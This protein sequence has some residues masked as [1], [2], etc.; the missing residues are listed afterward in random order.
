MGDWPLSGGAQ[1]LTT[2]AADAAASRGTT[3]TAPGANNTKGAYTELVASSAHDADALLVVLQIGLNA[4]GYL[5]DIAIGGAG[6][7][8][9]VVP[10]IPHGS[11]NSTR[12][13]DSLAVIVPLAIPAGTRISARYQASTASGSIVRATATLLKGNFKSPSALGV[14][15]ALGALTA[16]SRGT[17]ID[18]G[19]T[20]NTKGSYAELIASTA[21]DIKAL[22][23]IPRKVANGLS[24]ATWWLLDI[25]IGGAGSE[26]I[27]IADYALTA[28]DRD[29]LSPES[30]VIP[31]DIPAGSRVAARAA[32]SINTASV[33]TIDLVLLGVT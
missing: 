22:V 4:V 33:R 26:K 24:V 2:V 17:N 10:N 13:T 6:S 32:C 31:V 25:A 5:V 19:G 11:A 20:I 14:V 15:S 29:I 28:S 21:Y 30:T 7:E 12:D 1:K 8:K 27:V 16:S 3:V 9:V 23:V 18:P